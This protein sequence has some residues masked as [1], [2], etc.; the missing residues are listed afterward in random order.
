MAAASGD[1]NQLLV[2]ILEEQ[3]EI[4]L[5]KLANTKS[6]IAK[7]LV[8]DWQKKLNVLSED[9]QSL[10][11]WQDAYKQALRGSFLGTE[12]DRL[13]MCA[14]CLQAIAHLSSPLAD[15]LLKEREMIKVMLQSLRRIPIT[16]ENNDTIKRVSGIFT[17]LLS[18]VAS[19]EFER[20]KDFIPPPIQIAKSSPRS[21]VASFCEALSAFIFWTRPAPTSPAAAKIDLHAHKS[22]GTPTKAPRSA[23]SSGYSPL[24]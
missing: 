23:T 7:I 15:P 20:K 6:R 14:L 12:E 22:Y 8:E 5:A 3:N 19:F 18:N 4:L 16:D 1:I 2:D 11:L 13:L 21:G 17:R 10:E 9:A 24:Y